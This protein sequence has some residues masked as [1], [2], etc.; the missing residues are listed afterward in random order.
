MLITLPLDH[1]ASEFRRAIEQY[2]LRRASRNA[3]KISGGEL[4]PDAALNDATALFM[5]FDHLSTQHCGT[6]DKRRR[7]GLHKKDIHLI[8]LP[9][10]LDVGLS[11]GRH[12]RVIGKIR[13]MAHRNVV[14]IRFASVTGRETLGCSAI[15]CQGRS[16]RRKLK[17]ILS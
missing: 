16:K 8:P 11:A 4:L 9:F 14:R 5:G 1:K 10:D 15:A 2:L 7:N 3:D 12:K 13:K 6:H 17:K